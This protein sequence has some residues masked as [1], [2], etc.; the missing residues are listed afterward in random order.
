M[1]GQTPRAVTFPFSVAIVLL[2]EPAATDETACVTGVVPVPVRPL[3][4][5]LLPPVVLLTVIVAD[6]PPADDGVKVTL[7]VTVPPDAATEVFDKPLTTNCGSSETTVN[8]SACAA[9]VFVMVY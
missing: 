5:E 7:Y 1:A 2:I 3:V 6:F 4:G 9:P 8:P